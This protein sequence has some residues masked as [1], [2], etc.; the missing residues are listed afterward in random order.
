[1]INLKQIAEKAKTAGKI[2]LLSLLGA[3]ATASSLSCVEGY[4]QYSQYQPN[5]TLPDFFNCDRVIFNQDGSVNESETITKY[6]FKMDYSSGSLLYPSG[7]LHY[8]KVTA[9]SHLRG[10]K[11]KYVT[12]EM[13]LIESLDGSKINLEDERYKPFKDS[14]RVTIPETLIP[15]ED[16]YNK[17]YWTPSSTGTYKVVWRANGKEI[18]HSQFKVIKDSKTEE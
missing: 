15:H 6:K 11:G 18:G 12:G 5:Q 13:L 7:A 14:L 9:V 1:M 3:T 4:G 17:F 8:S 16:Y 2:G 10:Q